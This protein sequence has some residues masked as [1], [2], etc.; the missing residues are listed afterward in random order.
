MPSSAD[1]VSERIG[2]GVY[3]FHSTSAPLEDGRPYRYRLYTHCWETMRID[4]DG[5]HW[6]VERVIDHDGRAPLARG[7][8]FDEGVVTV[9]AGDSTRAT[10]RSDLGDMTL[11]LRRLD[12]PVVVPICA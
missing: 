12:G 6:T 9:D 7:D 11:V 1:P 8:P 2:E 3:R 10:Y 4:L 5:S